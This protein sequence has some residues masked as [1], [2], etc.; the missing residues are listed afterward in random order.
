M[1]PKDRK[2]ISFRLGDKT[3]KVWDYETG[4]CINTIKAH[5]DGVSCL[6]TLPDGRLVSGAEDN[7][8]KIWDN[9]NKYNNT[10]ILKGHSNVINSI[11]I[12]DDKKILSASADKIMKIWT[13]ER[14]IFSD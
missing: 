10:H 8:I 4:E 1:L 12:I 13:E 5:N 7:L 9:E 14:S 6:C 2:F 11:I 3:I